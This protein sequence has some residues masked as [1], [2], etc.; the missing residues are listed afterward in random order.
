MLYYT[1]YMKIKKNFSIKDFNTFSIDIKSKYFVEV[2]NVEDCKEVLKK[3]GDEKIFFLGG[4]SNTL[5][6]NDWDGLIIK[7]NFLGREIKDEDDEYAYVNFKAGEEWDDFVNW[8]VGNNYAGVENMVM[9]P[10]SVG[11]AVTQNIAAY[12]QNITDVLFEIEVLDVNSGEIIFLKPEECDFR[13]RSSKF[14]N[15]WRKKYVVVSA[16]FKLKKNAQTFELS[17]HERSGRFGSLMDELKSFAKEPY[18]LK[19]V[20]KAVRNQREK[21]LPAVEDYGTCGS[22]FKNPVVSMEEFKELEKK[23]PDLQSYPPEDLIYKKSDKKEEFVKIPAGRLLDELG[24]KGKCD[25]NVGVSEKHALCVV[26][27]KK[28]TGREVLEFIES[29]KKSVKD[30]YGVELEEEVNIV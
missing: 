5:F 19:D 26:T 27:N 4:G 8:A 28:A 11:G 21:R 17:Y 18:T 29:M 7:I 14:K 6:V 24:W 13:Y 20:S 15:E 16:T 25:C 2:D 22:F 9:I 23:I 30:S 3:F 12:G 10:G 1:V